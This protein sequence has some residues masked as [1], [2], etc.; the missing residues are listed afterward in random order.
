MLDLPISE[1]DVLN[2]FIV[3]III[4]VYGACKA[5]RPNAPRHH[6]R[7]AIAALILTFAATAGYS[8][9]RSIWTDRYDTSLNFSWWLLYAAIGYGIYK[10][11]LRAPERF[12]PAITAAIAL[13]LTSTIAIFGHHAHEMYKRSIVPPNANAEYKSDRTHL[14]MSPSPCFMPPP[15]L[16][17]HFFPPRDT[18][19]CRR[20]HDQPRQNSK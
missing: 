15:S 16:L 13:F 11:V 20:L 6:K 14:V 10:L 17:T 8:Y 7:F 1:R 3:L 4:I 12:R 18:P 9:L 2:F 5:W 19:E